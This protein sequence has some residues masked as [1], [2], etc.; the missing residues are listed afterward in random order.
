[1][2]EGRQEGKVESPKLLL[3]FSLLVYSK[4]ERAKQEIFIKDFFHAAALQSDRWLVC[5]SLF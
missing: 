2:K 4:T 3:S 1:M 5:S